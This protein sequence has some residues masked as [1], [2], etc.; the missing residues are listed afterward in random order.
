MKPPAQSTD[1]KEGP[2]PGLLGDVAG[3][4]G[5]YYA[6]HWD[7]PVAFECKVASDMAEFLGR[8]DP[9]RDLVLSAIGTGRVQASISLDGSRSSLA[10]RQAQLRWFIV[11]EAL[12]GTGIGRRLFERVLSFGRQ[13]G[14]GSIYLTTFRGLDA[15]AALYCTAG[16]ELVEAKAGSTWGREL[17][18]EKYM[19]HL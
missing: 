17:V 3:L 5:R 19:L 2:V 6:Q 16:F 14:F 4:H 12:R 9:A 15:A 8:Y 18:E 11:D 7:L 10:P 1:I 13:A